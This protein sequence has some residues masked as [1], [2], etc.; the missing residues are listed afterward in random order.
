MDCARLLI[1]GSFET[2]QQSG[3]DANLPQTQE[4]IGAVRGHLSEDV[5]PGFRGAD[6][7]LIRVAINALSI[8]ERELTLGPELISAEHRRLRGLFGEGD[9]D[10]L[11]WRLVQ[12]LR[13][14]THAS[15]DALTDHLRNTVAGQ[16]QIDQP[17]YSALTR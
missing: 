11:R 1:P 13:S 12:T 7:F 6:K 3:S 9:L 14:G 2:L 10:A 8:A 17:N 5:A 15:N 16:L 4:L